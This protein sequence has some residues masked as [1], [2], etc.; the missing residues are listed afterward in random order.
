MSCESPTVPDA[1]G[2]GDAGS[3]PALAEASLVGLSAVIALPTQPPAVKVSF[4]A[5]TADRA[6]HSSPLTSCFF[7]LEVCR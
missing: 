1:T 3:G 2:K 7:Q 4:A 6:G 5:P